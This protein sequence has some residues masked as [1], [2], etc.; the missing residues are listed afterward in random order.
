MLAIPEVMKKMTS[1]HLCSPGDLRVADDFCELTT[2]V[3][4]FPEKKLFDWPD[5][6]DAIT[7][8]VA[9]VGEPVVVISVL[10]DYKQVDRSDIRPIIYVL[11]S[12]GAGWDMANYYL[13]PEQWDDDFNS[14]L[15]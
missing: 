2:N 12:S 6:A 7:P 1:S 4:I 8:A 3:I 13:T 14:H 9:N 5:V 10:S 15:P 11:S